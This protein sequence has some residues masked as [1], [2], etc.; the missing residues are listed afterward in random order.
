MTYETSSVME[1]T[2]MLDTFSQQ[3]QGCLQLI[4]DMSAP[5]RLKAADL[6]ND[7]SIKLQH[8][9]I[10]D[11]IQEN[12]EKESNE[13]EEIEKSTIS[14]TNKEAVSVSFKETSEAVQNIQVADETN[15]TVTP[16]ITFEDQDIRRSQVTSAINIK[17]EVLEPIVE[18]RCI[19]EDQK[20]QQAKANYNRIKAG[21]T[22]YYN[23]KPHML[24]ESEH[25]VLHTSADGSEIKSYQCE[26]CNKTFLTMSQL[27]SHRWQHTRPFTCDFC[28]EKFPSKG[29]LVIHRRKHTG[30]KPFGCTECDQRF[31]TRSNLCRHLKA[32]SGVRNW[33]C[34]TCHQRFTEKRSLQ[35]HMRK[36]TGERPYSCDF[37]G[38]GKRFTQSGILSTHKLTHDDEKKEKCQLCGKLFRQKF[39][40]QLHMKRHEGTKKF[41]CKQCPFS[42]LTKS[43]FDRHC[44]THTGEKPYKCDYCDMSFSRP[45]N[46]KEH[47]ARHLTNPNL[48]GCSICQMGFADKANYDKHVKKVHPTNMKEEQ[49]ETHTVVIEAGETIVVPLM[50]TEDNDTNN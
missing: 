14:K 11:S 3:I 38:C 30:E 24:D 22:V 20:T 23:E 6:W 13:T 5:D 32:H 18:D 39:H 15:V 19:T 45:Q 25:E 17:C 36:H 37:P 26:H 1:D 2:N 41:F 42:F 48:M 27:T 44:L 7:A 40:L 31:S 10:E 50:D 4:I 9:L 21:E 49:I 34:S 12:T 43:D 35:I 29:G 8:I 33:S 47:Q 28:R 46:R 16:S